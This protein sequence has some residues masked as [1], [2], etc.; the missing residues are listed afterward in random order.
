MHGLILIALTATVSRDRPPPATPPQEVVVEGKRPLT[1]AERKAAPK[2]FTVPGYNPENTITLYEGAIG[3]ARCAAS[4]RLNDLAELRAVVDGVFNSSTHDRQMALL[5]RKTA[6]CGLGTQIGYYVTDPFP[7]SEREVGVMHRGA[8]M[9]RALQTYAPNL[10]LTREQLADPAIQKRFQDREGPRNRLR[11]PM[12]M[13]YLKV[14][15][16]LVQ[17]DPDN[18]RR[19]LETSGRSDLWRLG[20]R[21]FER[22]RDC[23]G[24]AQKVYADWFQLKLYL[25]DATYR[26]AVAVRNVPSLIPEDAS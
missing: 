2:G 26:W 9:L 25:A 21:M 23:V 18:S 8:F 20:A 12:D 13:A 24:G 5:L 3:A 15:T 14:A 11:I 1:E 16:C 6:T 17:R 19:M 10:K 4:G 22:N 7:A